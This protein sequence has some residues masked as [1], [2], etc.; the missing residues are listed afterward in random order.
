LQLADTIANA[1]AVLT[2]ARPYA[3]GLTTPIDQGLRLVVMPGDAEATA[4]LVAVLLQIG[5]SGRA[6]TGVGAQGH[7]NASSSLA[8]AAAGGG[9]DGACAAVCTA[10]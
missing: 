1:I 5:L 2:I 8:K 6:G 10:G 3:L 7:A 4:Q 9:V